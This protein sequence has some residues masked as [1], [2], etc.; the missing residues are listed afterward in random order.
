MRKECAKLTEE[1]A[2]KLLR[3]SPGASFSNNQIKAMRPK[4][5]EAVEAHLKKG[6]E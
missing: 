2:V 3:E 5:R 6:V 1:Q 4:V